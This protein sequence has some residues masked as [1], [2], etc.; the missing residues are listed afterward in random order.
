MEPEDKEIQLD[1]SFDL[2]KPTVQRWA[3]PTEFDG[4][5]KQVKIEN[6]EEVQWDAVVK[7]ALA[8]GR[9]APQYAPKDGILRRLTFTQVD[10]SGVRTLELNHPNFQNDLA[11]KGMK[12]GS[13]G[14]LR[15]TQ[16]DGKR[17]KWHWTPV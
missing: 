17:F 13:V 12:R 1:E 7:E 3:R 6:F 15:R 9:R 2:I 16:P 5:G 14:I 11:G 8:A 4:A 10:F